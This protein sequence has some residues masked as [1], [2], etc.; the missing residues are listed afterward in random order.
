MQ[1][2]KFKS[3]CLKVMERVKKT[4]RKVVITKRNVPIAK[5]VPLDVED[6]Q[7]L[8]KLKGTVHFKDNIMDSIEEDWDAH[9]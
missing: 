6:E 8:G 2:A 4:R 3:E 1:A 9:S 7:V 5:L